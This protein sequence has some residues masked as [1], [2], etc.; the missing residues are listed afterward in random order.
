MTSTANAL[1][2]VLEG[3]EVKIDKK[4]PRRQIGKILNLKV[5]YGGSAYT[6]KDDLGKTEEEAQE[7]LDALELAF[8][9]RAKW[10]AKS[11]QLTFKN[12][13]IL[14]DSINKSKCFLDK[15][16]EY[17]KLDEEI[18]QKGFWDLYKARK[19]QL[20]ASFGES[21]IRHKVS[22]YFKW[23]GSIERSSMNYPIQGTAAS[24]V[25]KAMIL[26]REA[27]IKEGLYD[28]AKLINQVHDELVVECP[29]QVS[30]QV[31]K[32]VQDCMIEAGK[33]FCKKVPMVVEPNIQT[34]WAK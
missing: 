21:E 24:I 14:L 12:G 19:W 11:K 15:Y 2:S 4:D 16:E 6:V 8:P 1:F 13:Y 26:V 33:V 5:G 27:F 20:G 18:N 32:I 28:I 31:A 17:K 25:K 22:K 29:Q 34:Y 23:K 30:E 9:E 3:R 10:Q 7:F